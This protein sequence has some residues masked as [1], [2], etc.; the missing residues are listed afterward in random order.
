MSNLQILMEELGKPYSDLKFLLTCFQ[1]VLRENNEPEL[2]EVMPWICDS[3]KNTTVDFT[4]KHFH[5][6]SVCFQLLNLAETNGAV[7]QRRKIEEGNSLTSVNGLWANSI[8]LLQE[9][10]ITENKI[11]DSLK[12]ISIQPVLTAHPTE[13]KRPVILKKYRELYLLLVKRENSMYNSYELEENRNEMK[14]V[15]SSIWHIDEF[16]MEKPTVETELD[17][18][19][20]YFVNVF[21]EVVQVLNR[22][23]V[24]AW[25]FSGFDEAKLIGNNSFPQ[26]KFGTWIGG[27]RDGH[28]LV[29][30]D[31]TRKTLLKLRVNAFLTVKQELNRLADDLSFYFE[32]SELPEQMLD[33]FKALVAETGGK[34][35]SIV[36]ASKNEA[37]KLIVK[38]FINKL[39]INIGS[40]Q[41]L[42]LKDKKGTYQCSKQLIEDLELLKDALLDKN[43]NDLAYHSVNRTIYFVKT[44]GFHLAELDI[45]QNSAYYHKA[46]EQLVNRSD[47]FKNNNN[48]WSDAEKK[49]FLEKELRSAR[50]FSREYRD[51]ETE[52]KNTI[53]CFQLLNNHISKYA[54][55]SI[56]SLIISMTQSSSDLL[57]VYILAREAGLTLFKDSMIMRL[58]VVPLFETIQDLMDSPAILEEYFSYP[59]VQNSLEYQRE[60]RNLPMKTQEVMIG[61]S[62]SNKD[63]GILAS[64]WFLYKAQKEITEVGRKFGIQIKFFHGKGGSI[65]RGAGPIHWFLRSLPHGTLSGNFKITEQGESI[66]KKFANKINAAYNLELM[67]AG[68]TLNTLLHQNTNDDQDEISDI[69]EFMGQE[70]FNVYTELLN[71]PHFLDYYQEATPIDV[72]EQ[73]KIGSRP[74]RRTGKRSFSDLRAIPWVFSWGQARYHITS[75]YGVGSTLEKMK[76]EHPEKYERLKKLIRKNQFVRYVFTNVDTSLAST[77]KDIM[78]LYAGLVNNKETRSAIL[79]LLLQELEKTQTLMN[80]LLGRPI[81]ERRKNHYYST[82]LR[83][84]ALIPL[85]NHQV[86]YIKKWRAAQNSD[87]S[88]KNETINQLLLSVN[89]IANAMG[90]TG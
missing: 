74:A 3:E 26:L 56:G 81:N 29:T 55:Y 9:K 25:E 2:A 41:L 68:N 31:V 58:H 71:N 32:I 67:L 82:Q 42:K 12:D 24:Q 84:E 88:L 52:A 44:F 86:E 60:Q 73:S 1:E 17:N 16:Y 85:H 61:Y 90:T 14:R 27:D 78:K 38:L 5:M 28:P 66:E 69:M 54:N 39:P 15:I 53:E 57:T 48:D 22:R 7:Q 23:L 13:A 45:R 19:I 47:P 65:S 30:A 79:D 20:H 37:F 89:A 63:G 46:L 83:A 62:D 18:V 43:Y 70:S 21:P 64:A 50:P 36:S 11:L 35:K 34:A 49:T 4:Q 72:I 80:E 51:L 40:S 33:R 76:A 10:G 8:K 77:D 59:E 6:F 87:A 75:W